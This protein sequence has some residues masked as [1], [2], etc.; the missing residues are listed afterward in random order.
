M[1]RTTKSGQNFVFCRKS[2]LLKKRAAYNRVSTVIYIMSVR[3][4]NFLSKAA[5]PPVWSVILTPMPSSLVK[6]RDL[7]T[8]RQ[9]STLHYSSFNDVVKP[10]KRCCPTGSLTEH[11]PIIFI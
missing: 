9:V 1:G 8:K 7:P 5:R 6:A 2:N 3:S 11:I 4:V 10:I